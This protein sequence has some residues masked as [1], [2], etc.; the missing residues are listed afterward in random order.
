MRIEK[1]CATNRKLVGPTIVAQKRL[2]IIGKKVP[3]SG[4]NFLTGLDIASGMRK[5]ALGQI[6][7]QNR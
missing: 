2:E 4:H 1:Q 3:K 6:T 5:E 7:H